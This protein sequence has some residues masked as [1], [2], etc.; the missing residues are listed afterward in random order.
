MSTVNA[1][2]SDGDAPAAASRWF[3]PGASGWWPGFYEGFFTRTRWGQ[4]LRRA[5]IVPIV[6]TLY[7]HGVRDRTVLEIGAGTGTYTSVLARAGASVEIREP[8]AAMR[9]YLVGRATRE[10]WTAV[11]I[12]DGGL[13]TNLRVSSRFPL[14]LAVGVL[15]YVPDLAPALDAMARALDEDGIVV[16]NVPTAERPSGTRNRVIERLGRRRVYLRSRRDVEF[17]ARRAG[18]RL[19]AEPCPA[20]VTDLYVLRHR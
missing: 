5:E 18:L 10:A 19:A 2:R 20:G 13:P 14:V 8:S 17:A 1:V 11:R 16:V 6:R 15:N 7:D 12:S 4:A 9:S 3:L